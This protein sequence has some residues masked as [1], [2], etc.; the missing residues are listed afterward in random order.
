MAIAAST[1]R[2]LSVPHGQVSCLC[3]QSS[4][5]SGI[6]VP[7]SASHFC[8]PFIT[9]LS[10]HL[11][12]KM[13]GVVASLPELPYI[14]AYQISN[15]HDPSEVNGVRLLFNLTTT[16]TDRYWLRSVL[17]NLADRYEPAIDEGGP[18]RVFAQFFHRKLQVSV[19]E[20]WGKGGAECLKGPED[21]QRLQTDDMLHYAAVKTRILREALGELELRQLVIQRTWK[22][23]GG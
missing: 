4:P 23:G 1:M 19:R 12:L 22:K 15:E 8:L 10:T 7:M 21:C 9:N 17:D 6:Y 11:N 5:C 3:Q 16:P 14:S 18:E 13:D 2:S 20:G